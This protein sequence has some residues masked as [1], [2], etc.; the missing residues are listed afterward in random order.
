MA[1][2]LMTIC[3]RLQMGRSV[4]HHLGHRLVFECNLILYVTTKSY[5]TKC[6][7]ENKGADQL[8]GNRCMDSTIRLLLKS[9]L[10]F[11]C[12]YRSVYLGPVRKPNCWF[13]HEAAQSCMLSRNGPVKIQWCGNPSSGSMNT[14]SLLTS[15]KFD[16]KL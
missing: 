3:L 1:W 13:S 11:L 5:L 7:G 2:Y 12:L 4:F 9:E 8:R 10:S 6:L 14:C 16:Y 15:N